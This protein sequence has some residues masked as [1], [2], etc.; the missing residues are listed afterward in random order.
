V[1]F[2]N[3]AA[4]AG[5]ASNVAAYC[6]AVPHPGPSSSHTGHPT[7]P[8]TYPPPRAAG[9]PPHRTADLPPHAARN[10]QANLTP[11]GPSRTRQP[12]LVT[13]KRRPGSRARPAADSIH[14]PSPPA[15]APAAAS[16]PTSGQAAT[17]AGGAARHVPAEPNPAPDSLPETICAP[18]D[19]LPSGSCACTRAGVG[20][21]LIDGPFSQD[22]AIRG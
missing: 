6:A 20:V 22:V 13:G 17:V 16:A 5:G 21:R 14:Q 9:L 15:P 18:T 4:A 7:G 11:V 10:G 8:P 19:A 12:L 3:L 2:R 1:A